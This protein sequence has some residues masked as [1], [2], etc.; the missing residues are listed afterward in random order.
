MHILQ[1]KDNSKE[2]MPKELQEFLVLHI[3]CIQHPHI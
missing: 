3:S 1:T 2:I